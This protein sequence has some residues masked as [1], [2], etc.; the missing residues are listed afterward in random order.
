[1]EING[2]ST[3]ATSMASSSKL[4]DSTAL[5][6]EKKANDVSAANAVKLIDSVSDAGGGSKNPS[7]MGRNVDIRV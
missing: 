6:A 7:H 1:M 5:W 2:V 4:G 3:M